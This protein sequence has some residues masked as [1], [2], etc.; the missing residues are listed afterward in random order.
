MR[1]K[2]NKLTEKIEKEEQLHITLIDYER[3][4]LSAKGRTKL[5]WYFYVSREFNFISKIPLFLKRA[6]M[7]LSSARF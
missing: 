7:N 6:E 4:G 3:D 5:E 2:C 1:V